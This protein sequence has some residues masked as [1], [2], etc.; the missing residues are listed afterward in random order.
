MFFAPNVG[1]YFIETYEMQEENDFE[2]LVKNSKQ[3]P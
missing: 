2:I 3:V 1:I